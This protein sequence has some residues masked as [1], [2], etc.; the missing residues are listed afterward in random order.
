MT[1]LRTQKGL[2]YLVLSEIATMLFYLVMIVATVLL[3][4]GMIAFLFGDGDEID[5]SGILAML[6]AMLIIILIFII[7]AIGIFIVMII[8]YY[9]MYAGRNEFGPEHKK[10]VERGLIFII[11]GHILL[12]IPIIGFIGNILLP[13]GKVYLIERIALPKDRKTV[14]LAFKLI[15]A[16][17]IIGFGYSLFSSFLSKLP[18]GGDILLTLQVLGLLLG[19]LGTI[20]ML[21][22][23]YSTYKALKNGQIYPSGS[24]QTLEYEEADVESVVVL[25]EDDDEIEQ[26]EVVVEEEPIVIGTPPSEVAS[27]EESLK[28]DETKNVKYLLLEC[29]GCSKEFDI[30]SD[31]K[32]ITCPH[33]GLEGEI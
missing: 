17:M 1:G 24:I 7:L 4:F 11:V 32:S 15:V 12:F 20:I 25:A 2:K 29:P 22:G 18:L 30:R 6:G 5:M 23:Y 16:S 3:I 14:K 19:F 21:L 8:G 10:K 31:Q 28:K 13:L 9:N 27:V 26:V 33:C